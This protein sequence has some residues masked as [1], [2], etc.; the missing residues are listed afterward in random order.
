MGYQHIKV[1]FTQYSYLYPGVCRGSASM[2]ALMPPAKSSAS[3]RLQKR[4]RPWSPSPEEKSQVTT[5]VALA[6][7]PILSGSRLMGAGWAK[8]STVPWM[9]EAAEVRMGTTGTMIASCRVTCCLSEALRQ[10][11]PS[12]DLQQMRSDTLLMLLGEETPP[13]RERSRGRRRRAGGLS[14]RYIALM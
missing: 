10:G 7:L 12:M 6:V 8:E 5:P 4:S 3:T 14:P 11:L 1:I 9:E 13:S 2:D